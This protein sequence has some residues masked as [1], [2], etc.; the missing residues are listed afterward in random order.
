MNEQQTQPATL[1]AIAEYNATAAALADLRQRYAG[2][3]Y[4]VTKPAEME[5]AR[6]ARREL[7]TLRSALERKRVEIKA[8]ALER[9]RLID[10]EAKRITGELLA[11]ENPIDEQIRAEEQRKEREKAERE[12]RERE[13]VAA[14][15][16]KIEQIRG[17]VLAAVSATA[18]QIAE[19]VAAL[20]AQEISAETF[21]ELTE[22]ATRVRTATLTKLG[23]M[24]DARAAQ[25]VEAERL[26]AERDQ[27]ERDQAAERERVAARRREEAAEAARREAERRRV[28]AIRARLDFI[29]GYPV[30]MIGNAPDQITVGMHLVQTDGTKWIE[31]GSFAEFTDEANAALT[32][33]LD[34]LVAMKVD[35]EKREAVA[36]EEQRQA[37]E[38][39]RLAQ[40]ERERQATV[41]REAAE[42]EARQRREEDE[43]QAQLAR[44]ARR[45]ERVKAYGSL[46]K[47]A[48]LYAIA[49]V[50]ERTGDYD[51]A[52]ARDEISVICEANLPKKRAAP[53]QPAVEARS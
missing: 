44:A 2:V 18:A 41:A 49:G 15:R 39:E 42:R 1:T 30:S 48:A 5:A 29:K 40:A 7:V 10:A 36:A 14:I 13:R 45:R 19:S 11:I 8:P 25:E 46:S 24:Y 20:Q 28:D 6:K 27:L 33:T 23:E 3:I 51:D 21:A 50:C 22:E 12:Q 32:R 4:D 35:A 34:E 47:E 9:A 16:A 43:R 38:R 31:S 53:A 26:K 17:A 37:R 52:A